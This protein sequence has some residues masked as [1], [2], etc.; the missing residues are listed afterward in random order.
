VTAA[1]DELFVTQPS[2]SAAVS[3]LA[4]EVGADLTERVGRSIRPTAAGEAFA[5]YA[6]DVIGLLEQGE[7][8]ALEASELAARELRIVAVTT[9]AEYVVP[10]LMQAFGERHPDVGLTLDVG[11]REY[12]LRQV[13]EHHADVA[14]GGRPPTDGERLVGDAFSDNRF[15][16][17]TSADDALAD[18]SVALSELS[19]RPWLLREQGS[20]TRTLTEH[21]LASH[22]LAPRVLT[23]GSNGA[24]KQAA[25]AG[26]GVSLQSRIAVELELRSGLLGRIRLRESLP[27]RHWYA[28]RSA[29]GPVTDAVAAFMAFTASQDARSALS[30]WAISS[31][32]SAGGDA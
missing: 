15:V 24:I 2:V 26:I 30:A 28:L 8:A 6:A 19:E 1:A 7:R 32:S 9:A 23:L 4:R 20:G 13:L 5:A 10:P 16:L 3:A 25:R 17:I 18:Q 21:F 11:N 31:E 22:E 27:A 29:M 14:V 12:V